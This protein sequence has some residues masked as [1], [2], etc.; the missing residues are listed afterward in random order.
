MSAQTTFNPDLQKWADHIRVLP[1]I[2]ERGRHKSNIWIFDSP[3]NNRRFI[4]KGDVAFIYSVL[5]EGDITVQSYVPEPPPVLASIDGE[6]RQTQ[7]DAEIH[8]TN[9]AIEWWEFKR[10]RDTGPGRTGRS[11]PQLSAQAQAASVAGVK[12]RVQSEEGLR[13]KE[14]LFDNWLM[15]CAA[16]TRCKYQTMPREEEAFLR[17]MN[18][19]GAV[20]FGTLLNEGGL[21]PAYVTATV[22]T[23]LQRGVIEADL[24]KSFFGLETVLAWRSQ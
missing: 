24:E 5:L 13:G 14:I 23:L 2:K 11:K 4:I 18:L 7:L 8:L 1:A 19:H 9:G 12:Y 22:A 15:L 21:D 10:L 16:I 6:V 3:K 17:Q 20:R